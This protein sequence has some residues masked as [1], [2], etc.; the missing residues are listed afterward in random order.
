MTRW[1]ATASLLGFVAITVLLA[2]WDYG[3]GNI[4]V[5]PSI[6]GLRH[7]STLCM[8]LAI[9]CLR[10]PA[11]ISIFTSLCTALSGLWNFESLIGTLA[12]HLAFIAMTNLR[13]RTY[14]RLFSDA[15]LAVSPVLLS[16]SALVVGALPRSGFGP[17][18][19]IYLGFLS[20]Y[21]PVSP[22]W[23]HAVDPRFLA[24]MTVLLS[25]LLVFSESWRGV[26]WPERLESYRSPVTLYYKFLPMAVMV[27]MTAAYYAFRSYDYTLL[28]AFLP[29]MALAIPGI[30]GAVN[31]FASAPLPTILF[32][33]VPA[34]PG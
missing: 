3:N 8:V 14:K 27:V 13:E 16:I 9:S 31:Y 1:K 30:L 20:A 26:F 7:L 33:A 11:R 15:A 24:W 22:F 28:I 32:L 29:F 21:N 5:A 18:Y 10:P 12:I 6:L 2:S 4:N 19:K 34:F 17:D 25:V 23:S